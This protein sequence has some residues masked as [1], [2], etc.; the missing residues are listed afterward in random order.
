M[1]DHLVRYQ[2]RLDPREGERVKSWAY[3]QGKSLSAALAHL[4]GRGLDFES[5]HSPAYLARVISS[6]GEMM[7]HLDARL[8]GLEWNEAERFQLVLGHMRLHQRISTEMV[9]LVRELYLCMHE[10]HHLRKVMERVRTEIEEDAKVYKSSTDSAG[11]SQR[12][13]DNEAVEY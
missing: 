10:N 4:V 5:G 12:S 9:H 1:V 6:Q 13:E 7:D 11:V 8:G 3:A 2:V